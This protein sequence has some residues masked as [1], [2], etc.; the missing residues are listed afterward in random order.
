MYQVSFTIIF[1][2]VFSNLLTAQHQ[3]GYFD[4]EYNRNEGKI[5]LH[6]HEDRLGEEFLYVNGLSAGIGSNDIGLDRGQLGAERIVSW[7]RTGNKLL[8]MQKNVDYRANSNNALEKQAVTEA[9]AQSALGGFTIESAVSGVLKIDITKFL[10]RDAHGVADRLKSSKQGNYSLDANRS[11]IW[12]ARTKN[13]PDNTE[14]DAITT[15]AG[16]AQGGWIR[17]VVPTDHTVTVHQH[18]SFIRLPDSNYEP[19]RFHPYCGYF[20][21]SYYD[22]A[23]PIEEDIEQRF[24][25]RHRLKKK[26]PGAPVSEAVE[27]IVYYIDAGCPEPI[28]SAL[29]DGAAWWDQAFQAAGYAPGTFQIK[30]LPTGADMMDVRYNVI[31][32]IHRSTRG[33]SYGASVIDP[34]TGEIIKGHVSLGSLRV[35]QDFLIAQGLL[36]PYGENNDNHGPMK[37]MALARLRQLAA[38]EVGHTIG[39]AHNFA[40]SYNDKASV[41]DYPHPYINMDSEGNISLT[42]AYDQNIGKWDQFTIN[43]GYQDFEDGNNEQAALQTMIDDAQKE[44]YLFISD[45]DARP[46][47]GAHPHAHLWDNGQS[48][49]NELNRLMEIRKKVLHNIGENTIRT[50]TPLSELEKI[51]VPIYLLHRYQVDATSKL[52]GGLQYQYFVKGDHYEH[53]VKPVDS[54]VQGAA[55]DA[56]LNTLTPDALKVPKSLLKLISP[57]AFG[58]PRSRETFDSK[59]NPTFDV[60]APAESHVKMTMDFLLDKDRLTRIHRQSITGQSTVNLRQ[61]LHMISDEIFGSNEQDPYE[62]ALRELVQKVYINKLAAVAFGAETDISMASIAQ[63]EVLRLADN[64]HDNDAH[65][66]YLLRQIELI[67]DNPQ[68]WI[69]PTYSKL[70]PGSPIGCD[71]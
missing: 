10:L 71:H 28:K 26:N 47:G 37:E 36:S 52:I 27:P 53:Q 45:R 7:V 46:A 17:S 22:Y 50:G 43:Y 21:V 70:P 19:R 38:H 69:E 54:P 2:F 44:G 8:L 32:W 41:M 58:Y 30:E 25:T 33:W 35:R 62:K 4:F 23:V 1:S 29:M 31:Q 65:Q 20:P 6:V 67:K 3:S 68:E 40:A 63:Y 24:I 49:V 39:L 16:K 48:A 12:M 59:T 11:A 66:Q 34:R 9:F 55:I 5:I 18:H 56:I 14:F 61:M 57:P 60:L 15:F 64:F 42:N 13:F 51:L